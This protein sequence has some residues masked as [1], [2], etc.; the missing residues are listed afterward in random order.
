MMLTKRLLPG[1]LLAC[2]F[3]ALACSDEKETPKTMIDA[4]DEEPEPEDF[5]DDF[6]DEYDDDDSTAKPKDA[7]SKKDAGVD[8]G[9]GDA[10]RVPSMDSG[11][12]EEEEDVG[13][14]NT[15]S[16]GGGDNNGSGDDNTG[17]PQ[18]VDVE[19]DP[20]SSDIGGEQPLFDGM[21]RPAFQ[22]R[23]CASAPFVFNFAAANEPEILSAGNLAGCCL[24]DGTCGVVGLLPSRACRTFNEIRTWQANQAPGV[25]KTLGLPNDAECTYQRED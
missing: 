9:K 21:N 16:Q 8:G 15:G 14:E 23:N 3:G 17:G 19:R 24:S 13:S 20:R 10:G 18:V 12:G 4:G 25:V 11:V 7:G 5:G 2:C 6:E 22:T 1:V